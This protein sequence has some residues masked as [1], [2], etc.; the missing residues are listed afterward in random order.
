MKGWW[1]KKNYLILELLC[2]LD[3]SSN[4]LWKSLPGSIFYRMF[5]PRSETQNWG[6][7]LSFVMNLFIFSYDGVHGIGFRKDLH[8]IPRKRVMICDIQC[9]GY[10]K[11]K[12]IHIFFSLHSEV[13][14]CI[15]NS[16]LCGSLGCLLSIKGERGKNTSAKNKSA[17]SEDFPRTLGS[18]WRGT[19]CNH[20]IKPI[21]VDS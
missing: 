3:E 2:V 8:S 9:F 11:E 15:E 21:K 16:R 20:M 12:F 5:L 13:A 7:E 1:Q 18:P 6:D 17:V 4:S 14:V 19:K 10:L